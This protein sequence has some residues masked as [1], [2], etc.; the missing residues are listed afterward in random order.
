[1]PSDSL[2]YFQRAVLSLACFAL[3]ARFLD[4]VCFNSRPPHGSEA[5]ARFP[6]AGELDASAADLERHL[7]EMAEL[8][9][10]LQG[11]HGQDHGHG[12]DCASDEGEGGGAGGGGAPARPPARK[13]HHRAP[14]GGGGLPAAEGAAPAQRGRLSKQE[15]AVLLRSFASSNFC[16]NVLGE[17]DEDAAALAAK[18]LQ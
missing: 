1:M 8:D 2:F 4:Y 10:Q 11:L 12:L 17:A 18:G 16:R 5:A 14:G 7:A 6:A 13:P 15:A 3:V 9:Q